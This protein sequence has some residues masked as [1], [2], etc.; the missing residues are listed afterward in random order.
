M[1]FQ[2]FKIG[3]KEYKY[4]QFIGFSMKLGTKHSGYSGSKPFYCFDNLKIDD[5]KLFISEAANDLNT[6]DLSVNE[7]WII[8]NCI[9]QLEKIINKQQKQVSVNWL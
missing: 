9:E 1:D 4:I 6:N 8:S 2:T 3:N 5:A 7:R